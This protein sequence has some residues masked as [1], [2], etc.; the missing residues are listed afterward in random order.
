MW[1]NKEYVP[2]NMSAQLELVPIVSQTLVLWISTGDS[3][4]EMLVVVARSAT[5]VRDSVCRHLSARCDNKLTV[6]RTPIYKMC[7]QEGGEF[8]FV[9]QQL[10]WTMNTNFYTRAT[11]SSGFWLEAINHVPIPHNIQSLDI[12]QLDENVC[13]EHLCVVFVK[14]FKSQSHQIVRFLGCAIGRDFSERLPFQVLC[15]D[16]SKDWWYVIVRML[17]RMVLRPSTMQKIDCKSNRM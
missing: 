13:T 8:N 16:C 2:T 5:T 4:V 17:I 11:S 7:C 9:G 1:L 3:W 6:R 12:L 15:W 14:R 10:T